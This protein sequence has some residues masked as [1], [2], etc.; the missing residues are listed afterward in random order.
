MEENQTENNVDIEGENAEM[1]GQDGNEEQGDDLNIEANEEGVDMDNIEGEPGEEGDVVE[2][3]EVEDGEE[4]Q[5]IEDS[6]EVP[7]SELAFKNGSEE[8]QSPEERDERSHK[9]SSK[10]FGDKSVEGEKLS[11]QAS[12]ELGESNEEE[13]DEGLPPERKIR[14]RLFK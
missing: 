6:Q 8:Q 7:D 12:E 10:G 4:G 9:S 13:D 14:Y 2:G 11:V 1:E 5:E 3:E